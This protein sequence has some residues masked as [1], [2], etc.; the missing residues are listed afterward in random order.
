MHVTIDKDWNYI[1]IYMHTQRVW[2]RR[3]RDK[4]KDTRIV[5]QGN[6]QR[7]RELQYEN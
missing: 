4:K 6:S 7:E 3:H 1:Y 5:Q 2:E